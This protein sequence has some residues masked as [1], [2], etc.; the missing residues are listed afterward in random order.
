VPPVRALSAADFTNAFDLA[1]IIKHPTVFIVVVALI[2]TWA[3]MHHIL[4]RSDE[5]GHCSCFAPGKVVDPLSCAFLCNRAEYDF[6]LSTE[7]PKL[8]LKARIFA[9][10]YTPIDHEEGIWK[11]PRWY[12]VARATMTTFVL[13][14]H[15]WLSIFF[16]HPRDLYTSVQRLGVQATTLFSSLFANA[17]FFG[18]G[19][20]TV[21]Q[22]ISISIYS[23]L[24]VTPVSIVFPALFFK[25]ANIREKALRKSELLPRAAARALISLT[26]N[27]AATQEVG[28]WVLLALWCVAAAIITF[29]YGMQVPIVFAI[30]IY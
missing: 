11:D 26:A 15:P 9:M 4:K 12:Q 29:V 10:K 23:S 5:E 16:H 7:N 19:Q 21:A 1:N 14:E 2:S 28:S 6:L 25:A 30:G 8:Y 3:C 24:A 18:Q 13:L 20:A 27:A 17:A 22:T